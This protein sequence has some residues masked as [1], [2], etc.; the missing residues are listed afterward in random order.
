MAWPFNVLRCLHIWKPRDRAWGY[1]LFTSAALRIGNG[2]QGCEPEDLGLFLTVLE[3]MGFPEWLDGTINLDHPEAWQIYFRETIANMF[4]FLLKVNA[5]VIGLLLLFALIA[6]IA[7]RSGSRL[8]TF[9][10]SI[11]RIAIPCF[12]VF[13]ST[14]WVLDSVRSSKW[15]AG[16]SSGHTLM[17]PFPPSTTVWPADPSISKGSTTVPWRYDVLVGTRLDAK[18]IGAYSRWMDFHP[19][20]AELLQYVADVGGPLYRSYERGLPR[21]FKDHLIDGAFQVINEKGGRFLQQDYRTGDWRTMTE[22]ES[23]EYVR[24]VL[25]EGRKSLLAALREE[26]NFSLLEYRFGTLRGTTLSWQ[27]QTNLRKLKSR[28]FDGPEEIAPLV[29]S[30]QVLQLRR[31][32]LSNVDA[33]VGSNEDILSRSSGSKRWTT[34]RD[35]PAKKFKLH[36]ELLFRGAEGGMFRVTVVGFAEDNEHVY[37]SFYGEDG[38]YHGTVRPLHHSLLVKRIR[39]EE[40]AFVFGNYLKNGEWFPGRITRVRPDATVDILY[41]DGDFEE[42]VESGSYQ[43]SQGPAGR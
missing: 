38:Y 34:F 18:T 36:D 5:G 14:L 9:T 30:K 20:N 43:V 3:D 10:R 21:T 40:G 6:T 27:S 12:I 24:L 17:R 2:Q 8:R 26:V 31:P 1:D 7:N 32:S 29:P 33:T 28:L 16:I 13:L 22:K 37:V 19:G 41:D 15:G 25:F 4:N 39:P 11:T 42:R 23:L 35:E